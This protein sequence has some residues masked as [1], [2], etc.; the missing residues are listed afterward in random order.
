MRPGAGAGGRPGEPRPT[1]PAINADGGESGGEG[2]D[3][4]GE[5]ELSREGVGWDCGE[6]PRRE[7]V[8]GT[9]PLLSPVLARPAPCWRALPTSGGAPSREEVAIR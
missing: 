8:I 7:L 4:G 5:G 9:V 2:G 1:R 6:A 3:S